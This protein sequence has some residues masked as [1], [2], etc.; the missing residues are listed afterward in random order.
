MDYKQPTNS[1]NIYD[2]L[3]TAR[4]GQMVN[5]YGQVTG[6]MVNPYGQ[7]TGQI[8][9]GYVNQYGQGAGYVNQNTQGTSYANQYGQTVNPY[10]QMTGQIPNS[11]GEMTGQIPMGYA[12]QNTQNMGYVNQNTQ[13]T[14]YV[15]QNVWG[16]GYVNQYGQMVNPYG[17]VTG[18]MVNPY[19]QV[20]GQMPGL[21]TN[22]YGQVVDGYGNAYPDAASA[23]QAQQQYMQL[24]ASAQQMQQMQ[25]GP[26]II[27]K[28]GSKGESSAS[29]EDKKKRTSTRQH[30]KLG[31]TGHISQRALD[32]INDVSVSEA[33][34]TK[35]KAQQDII[36]QAAKLE[37][38]VHVE[39]KAE[40][41]VFV[42]K[43]PEATQLPEKP[44]KT[45]KAKK[46]KK[47]KK[48]FWE[49]S[50]DD[51]PHKNKP[52]AASWERRKKKKIQIIVIVI[53][54][55]VVLCG[56]GMFIHA[57]MPY[58]TVDLGD[59]F[60]IEYGGYNTNGTAEAVVDDDAVDELLT[61]LKDDY[62]HAFI[63]LKNPEPEDYAQFRSSLSASLSASS[64]LSNGSTITLT[65]SYDDELAQ[66]LKLDVESVTKAITVNELVRAT[67]IS[68]DQ[69]FEDVEIAYEGISPTLTATVVN[70]SQ[71]P[72]LKSVQYE[73]VEPKE[74]YQNGD[75]IEV[76]ATYD[77][78]AALKLQYVVDESAAGT[79]TY[80]V[81]VDTSYVSDAADITSDIVS[82]AVDAGKAAFVDANEYGVRIYC[83]ANLVPVYI[84]KKATFEWV[85]SRALSAYF[86]TVFPENAGSL[87]NDYNDLD[88][89]YEATMTQADGVSCKC[90]CVVR[91]SNFVKNADGSIS[92]DFSNPSIMSASYYSARAKK[93][94]VDSYA[95]THEV[96]KVL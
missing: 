79:Y 73:I 92:Y 23:M 17:Q 84:N 75:E 47:T 60:T 9:A 70:N 86:K 14:G 55:A 68:N 36:E 71:H 95:D 35:E 27:S 54:L 58:E 56:A 40:E 41:P 57:M 45:K 52:Q 59:M 77:S 44:K 53:F 26:D 72:F 63:H 46:T 6:Q 38:D 11:Y 85:S 74:T 21:Y 65:A 31:A 22:Q 50:P 82:A 91:F 67:V 7:V 39:E 83:E 81:S 37:S 66:K 20:T 15:N 13:G 18:Q 33:V 19:G 80:T 76:C 5:P 1:Q 25:G 30:N 89:I 51:A 93:N 78:E 87:G 8:P 69:L 61:K 24:N 4:T 2:R 49:V 96:T 94:V 43:R 88:I 12:N 10:G 42:P 64:G 62:D 3:S 48:N 16:N 34:K 90:Y 28:G 29:E 32:T